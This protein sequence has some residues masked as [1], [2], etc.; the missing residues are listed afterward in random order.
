VLP[1]FGDLVRHEAQ[2]ADGFDREA[3]WLARAAET[4]CAAAHLWSSSQVL[5]VPR[6]YTRLPAWPQACAASATAGWPVHIRGSGGGLVPLGPG[7]LNL[8]L[9]WRAEP[10]APIDPQAIYRDLCSLLS[11]ALA[12]L[13]INATPQAVAGSF[14]DGRFNL[15]VGGRKIAGTAQ[16]WRR[17]GKDQAVLAHAVIVVSAEP[18]ALT[19]TANRFEESA[20]SG[21]RYRADA[22][23]NVVRAWCDMHP[24]DA[25]LADPGTSL[26]NA[27]VAEL[28]ETSRPAAA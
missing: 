8:S 13:A 23:T 15:A 7:Q 3:G 25:P 20:A 24:A 21:R 16:A 28:A 4:G 19:E 12:R 5:A 26:A 17:I 10:A 2:L 14:C 9:V 22:L 18:D 11:R 6:S 27:I 1:A